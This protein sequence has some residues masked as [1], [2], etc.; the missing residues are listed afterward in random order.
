MIAPARAASEHAHAVGQVTG[1]NI[2]GSCDIALR[3]TPSCFPDVVGP[4]GYPL[5][6]AMPGNPEIDAMCQLLT[7]ALQQNG[8]LFDDL[9]GGGEQPIWTGEAKRLRGLKIDDQVELSELLHRH[10]GRL[11]SH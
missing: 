7:H 2:A 5:I 9:V 4:S 11:F 6:A 3:L 10:I 8:S 1:S